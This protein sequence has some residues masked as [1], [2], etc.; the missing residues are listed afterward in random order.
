MELFECLECLK[1]AEKERAGMILFCWESVS[2]FIDEGDGLTSSRERES[3]CVLVLLPTPLGT[4][5]FVSAHNTVD[6][7]MHVVDSIVFFW[8]GKCRRL[9]YCRTNVGAYSTVCVLTYLE[10]CK[11]PF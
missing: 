4:R 1:L 7:L 5:R 8:Y 3:V 11:V 2:P 6:A 10:G 9:P